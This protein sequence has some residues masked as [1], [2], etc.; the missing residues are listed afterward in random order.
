MAGSENPRTTGQKKP[1]GSLTDAAVSLLRDRILDLTL[2]PGD[3]LDERRLLSQFQLSRTPVR[4]AINRL[5]SEGLVEVRNNRGAYVRPMNLEDLLTL[6]DA[7]VLSE[8]MV[9]S[10]CILDH[11]DLVQDLKVIQGQY[12]AAFVEL[13][14]LKIT[15][16]NASFHGRMAAATENSFI[17]QY[18]LYLHNL[19]RRASFYIYRREVRTS[20]HFTVPAE[21]L[22]N[23]H[24]LIMEFI[25]SG[26]RS[27]LIDI[28]TRH[29]LVFRERM[30]ILLRAPELASVDF[31]I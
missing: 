28:V 18:S 10:V 25:D 16:V 23:H 15:E 19:A 7:Y 1:A 6:L 26:D 2:H 24:K 4:E 22:H 17:A 20:G 30:E 11:P 3:R 12:E 8:R 9:A 31:R 21:R 13:D 5:V 27:G 29:A 14:L